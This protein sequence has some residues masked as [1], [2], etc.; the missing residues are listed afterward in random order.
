[1]FVNGLLFLSPLWMSC[2]TRVLKH[3]VPIP[4]VCSDHEKTV[5]DIVAIDVATVPM[6]RGISYGTQLGE[7]GIHTLSGHLRP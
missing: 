5:P 3:V 4:H 2:W 7:N 1:M 6:K